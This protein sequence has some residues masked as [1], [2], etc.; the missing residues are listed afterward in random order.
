MT[1]DEYKAICH[2]LEK[3]IETQWI[4]VNYQRQ[5]ISVGG[6]LRIKDELKKMIKE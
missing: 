3:E 4:S 6:V 1:R 2:L 5:F